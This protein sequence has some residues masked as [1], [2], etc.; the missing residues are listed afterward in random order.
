MVPLI[1]GILIAT[2][3]GALVVPFALAALIFGAIVGKVALFEFLGGA[4]GRRLGATFLQ[5]SLIA[6]IVGVLMITLIYMVPVLGLIALGVVSIWGLGGAVTAAFW[7]LKKEM[8]EKRV[9][10]PAAAMAP[11]GAATAS[12]SAPF[13]PPA[14]TMATAE[15]GSAA[16]PSASVPLPPVTGNIPEA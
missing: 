12:S 10:P 6:F 9:I 8:P 2:G 11:A 3:V 15:Q 13:N 1:F 7:G 4:F 14:A 5:N 16:S